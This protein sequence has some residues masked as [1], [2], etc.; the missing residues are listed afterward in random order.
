MPKRIVPL[1]DVKVRNA[2]PRGKGFKLS[3][4]GG[5]YLLVSATGGK[6]GDSNIV[7]AIKRNCSL[8]GHIR[9][10]PLVKHGNVG[11]MQSSCWKMGLI[12]PFIKKPRK[13]H[14]M[15]PL[16]TAL[17]LSPGNG[18]AIRKPSG[19]QTTHPTIL[20]RLEKDILPWIGGIPITDV[21]AKDIKSVVDRVKSRGTMKRQDG[22]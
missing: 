10:C 11:T 19:P 4:G 12:H 16:Q 21:T 8:W 15:N 17:R 6:L 18:M 1:S 2:K 14:E 5:L 7:M 22:C 9:L 20:T 3:D 13:R